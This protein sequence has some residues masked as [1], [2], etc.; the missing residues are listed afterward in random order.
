M[1]LSNGVHTSGHSRH[2]KGGGR[3]VLLTTLISRKNFEL[4]GFAQRFSQRF[5]MRSFR[6][7]FTT[8]RLDM[9][10]SA[11][12]RPCESFQLNISQEC[13]KGFATVTVCGLRQELRRTPKI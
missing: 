7:Y 4:L 11:I 13:P 2:A 3:G 5:K 1:T 12:V 8:V 10:E 9:R 6:R